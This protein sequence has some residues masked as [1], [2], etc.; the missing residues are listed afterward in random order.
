MA[1]VEGTTKKKVIIDTDPGIGRYPSLDCNPRLGCRSTVLL[2]V[3]VVVAFGSQS[4]NR[5][6]T[7]STEQMMRWPSSWH[8]GRRSWRCWASP[9]PSATSTPPS[10]P[11]TRSTW[12]AAAG[13]AC[14]LRPAFLSS[15]TDT[16]LACVPRL[17]FASD[18]RDSVGGCWKDRHP[19]GR[20]IPCNNQGS[21]H[22]LFVPVSKLDRCSIVNFVCLFTVSSE[23]LFLFLSPRVH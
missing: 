17:M 21:C 13:A 5:T 7:V 8:C 14:R 9:L 4:T 6:S 18:L 1:A 3:P 2:L 16:L 20:G 23:V 12:Y 15:P 22:H 10:P 19:R 11:A